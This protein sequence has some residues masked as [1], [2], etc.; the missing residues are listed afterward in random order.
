MEDVFLCGTLWEGEEGRL[1]NYF[2][3]TVWVRKSLGWFEEERFTLKMVMVSKRS[4]FFI[5]HNAQAC[6]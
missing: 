4:F 3:H 2:S 1:W 6:A 5:K